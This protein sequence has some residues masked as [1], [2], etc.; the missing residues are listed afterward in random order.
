VANGIWAAVDIG[1]TNT[2]VAIADRD[3]AIVSE[4][5]I[6][7]HAEEGSA[8][9]LARIVSA[10]EGIGGQRPVAIGVGVPGLA[11]LRRGHTL[12]L[13]NLTGN[14]RDVPVGP[15]LSERLGCPAYLLND[16]RMATLGELTFGLGRGV[17]DMLFLAIGTGIGG[18]VVVDGK[19]RLGPLGAA[20]EIGHQT[21][22][23]DGPLCGC[24]NRGC[25]ETLASGTAIAAEGMRLMRMGLAPSLHAIVA[26]VDGCVTAKAMAQ[27]DDEA[28]RDCI[29][30]AA[31]WLGIGIANAVS[32]LHPSLVVLGGG[33][34]AI[35]PLYLDT[36]RAVV[37]DRVR[38]FPVDDLRIER[39][40]LGDKAGLYGG[41]ALAL[42]GHPQETTNHASGI[43]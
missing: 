35:G 21:L 6:A 15:V 25:L 7:T 26:G 40:I 12:F 43:R 11:D 10:V 14:W 16:V 23:P 24:G 33:V 20:G 4:D 17:A 37:R 8:A 41:I 36:V 31:N 38:M 13:P 9:V 32:L 22:I 1:G 28:V 27:A 29:R 18:G 34:A 3:G 39:S 2:S 42:H 19:L 5:C 30:R